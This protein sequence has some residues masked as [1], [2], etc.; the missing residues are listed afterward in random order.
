MHFTT[1]FFFLASLTHK[2]TPMQPHVYTLKH[3]RYNQILRQYSV[4]FFFIID[5]FYLIHQRIF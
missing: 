1:V 2:H 5:I 4:R 3:T